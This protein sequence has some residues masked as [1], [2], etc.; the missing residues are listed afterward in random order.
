MPTTL[1]TPTITP[2]TKARHQPEIGRSE[3]AGGNRTIRART[4]FGDV[5]D[6]RP[7]QSA[8]ACMSVIAASQ[9]QSAWT[10]TSPDACATR[11]IWPKV[12][13]SL[14]IGNVLVLPCVTTA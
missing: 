2:N 7:R 5:F 4:A 13:R 10:L 11:D 9:E 14:R 12:W 8:S 1:A 6:V 3:T